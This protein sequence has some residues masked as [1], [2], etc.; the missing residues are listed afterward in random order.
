MIFLPIFLSH[1]GEYITSPRVALFRVCMTRCML[2]RLRRLQF[3]RENGLAIKLI[4][5]VM[6]DAREQLKR[7]ASRRVNLDQEYVNS[8]GTTLV[9]VTVV[10][11]L[12]I[13]I[14]DLTCSVFGLIVLHTPVSSSL[15]EVG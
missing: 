1:T 13:A 10:V 9:H 6:G 3:E 12:V 14:A 4:H 15:A 2:I 11:S 8:I 7:R 5:Y